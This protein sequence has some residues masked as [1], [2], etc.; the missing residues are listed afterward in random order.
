VLCR[1]LKVSPSGFYDWLGR[2][3]SRRALSDRELLS[4]IRDIH[5]AARGTYGARRVHAELT[6]GR[7]ITVGRSRIERLMRQEG[8]RACIGGVFDTADTANRQCL[9]ITCNASSSPMRP[10]GSG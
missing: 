6:L 7:S 4:V 8:C 1:V 5:V 9:T 3:P 2:A 10:I